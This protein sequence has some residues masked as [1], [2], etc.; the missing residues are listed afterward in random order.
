[1]N[2]DEYTSGVYEAEAL[3]RK[4]LDSL[5]R[6]YAFSGNTVKAGDV[7]ASVNGEIIKVNVIKFTRGGSVFG[8]TLPECVYFGDVLTKQLKARK[9]SKRSQMFKSSVQSINGKVIK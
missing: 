6:E 1:M 5:A 7:I 9:D 8:S 4:K 3:H 2:E